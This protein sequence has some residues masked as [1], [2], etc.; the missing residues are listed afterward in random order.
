MLTSPKLKSFG[1]GE[2]Q[3]KK[4][5]SSRLAC[6]RACGRACIYFLN[7]YFMCVGGANLLLAM[8]LWCSGP[9]HYT[10]AEQTT[11]IK[12]VS[13]V[14]PQSGTGSWN[15][16]FYPGVAFG[17]DGYLV[18]FV[19]ILILPLAFGDRLSHENSSD[20]PELTL[21]RFLFM[22]R[23]LVLVKEDKEFMQGT[24]F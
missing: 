7:W 1:K 17:P 15:T 13:S 11:K 24:I 5:V 9:V 6:G 8:P 21:R 16:G 3:F 10:D 20:C 18:W 22:N 23:L 14:Q 19:F 2:L 4:K 12:P